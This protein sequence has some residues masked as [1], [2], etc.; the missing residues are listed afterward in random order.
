VNQID[1]TYKLFTVPLCEDQDVNPEKMY[2]GFANTAVDGSTFT[3][4]LE[5]IQT[6]YEGANMTCFLD[7]F[8]I[9]AGITNN[10]TL[11]NSHIINLISGGNSVV[12]G[13]TNGFLVEPGPGVYPVNQYGKEIILFNENSSNI[14]I[15]FNNMDGSSNDGNRIYIGNNNSNLVLYPLGCVRFVYVPSQLSEFGVWKLVSYT[16]GENTT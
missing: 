13:F 14:T 9:T 10:I 8:N 7:N 2:V 5:N 12:T 3:V 15:T 4:M 16:Q 1:N 11:P 6:R